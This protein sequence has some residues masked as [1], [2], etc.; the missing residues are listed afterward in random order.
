MHPTVIPMSRDQRKIEQ[1]RNAISGT[2]DAQKNPKE[3]EEYFKFTESAKNK[4]EVKLVRSNDAGIFEGHKQKEFSL[5]CTYQTI[6]HKDTEKDMTVKQFE[7]F[8]V[9]S[10]LD[11]VS[12]STNHN[13]GSFHQQY[14]LNGELIAV[15]V[16]DILELCLSSVYFFYD[17]KYNFLSLGK[18]SA[19]QEIMLTRQ[20]KQEIDSF[21]YYYMGYY[22]HTCPK[23]RYK[24]EYSGS[25]LLC[26]ET[27]TWHP[28]EKA[29]ALLDENKYSRFAAAD[30]RAPAPASLKELYIL[31]QQ[32]AMRYPRYRELR[33]NNNK[34]EDKEI[35][36]LCQLIGKK[37]AECK[38][39][40]YRSS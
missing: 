39:I 13:G 1:I 11:Y 28:I 18:V 38:L 3:I 6:I 19:L 10:P 8:L 34:E 7:R 23:M 30:V 32:S 37:A 27:Y 9:N 2:K 15:A 12:L 35:L 22:I 31:Y 4:F 33:T 14:W 24:G 25:S 36:E 5:Y 40:L 21:K 29:R 17:P 26:P 16:L 20:I